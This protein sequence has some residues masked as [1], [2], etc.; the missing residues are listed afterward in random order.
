MENTP[1]YMPRSRREQ[2]IDLIKSA[3]EP[4]QGYS[5]FVLIES[6]G[7]TAQTLAQVDQLDD[8]PL[9]ASSDTTTDMPSLLQRSTAVAEWTTRQGRRN[10]GWLRIFSGPTGSPA[11]IGGLQ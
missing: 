2:A 8:H 6:A 7:S 5:N 9:A 1:G 10:L 3:A 11:T 4:Y